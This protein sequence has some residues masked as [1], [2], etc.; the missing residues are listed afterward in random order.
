MTI[1]SKHQK[2]RQDTSTAIRKGLFFGR[3]A[4]GVGIVS[5]AVG[6]AVMA[7]AYMFVHDG[8]QIFLFASA[9]S[10][11]LIGA[12]GRYYLEQIGR[13]LTPQSVW[14]RTFAEFMA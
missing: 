6:M 5:L 3:M 2:R 12:I 9:A 11:T 7:Y 8:R 4:M 14:N 1:H 13:R 10:A